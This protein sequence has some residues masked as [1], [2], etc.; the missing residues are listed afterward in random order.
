MYLFNLKRE[1][2]T[3]KMLFNSIQFLIFFI[4][5]TAVYFLIHHKYKWALLLAASIFFYM[6][7]FPIYILI[8]A[9]LILLT[10]FSAKLIE[11][12]S[13][14]KKRNYFIL[15]LIFTCAALFVFKYFN[16]FNANISELA[17]FLHWNYSMKTLS[18]I[19]PIGLSF[20]TF[21]SLSYIIEVYRGR[22]KAEKHLG[23]YSLYILFYPQLVAGPIERPYNLIHQ[24]YEEHKFE[25]QRVV[26][27]LQL[28]LWGFFLKVVIADRAAM[29]VNPIYDNIRAYSGVSLIIAT[30]LFAFQIFCDFA[31][32]SII[33]I[34][35]AKIMGFELMTN[36]KRPYFSKS[37]AEFWRRWH[38]SLS[39]WFKDYVYFPL[40]GS[41]VRKRRIIFN[42][43]VVFLISGLWHG[44]AWTFLIWGGLHGMYM[45]IS[46]LTRH[47]REKIN[48]NINIKINPKISTAIQVF[49]TFNLVCLGWIF[50]RAN[51]VSDAWYIITHLFS[52]SSL[53]FLTFNVAGMGNLIITVFFIFVLETVHYIQEKRGISN[54]FSKMPGYI[55]RLCYVILL[56][57]ILLFGVFNKTPFIYFQF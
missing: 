40:G 7:M 38:I 25:V 56:L 3:N 1:N 8:P 21:Q 13:G 17:K 55:R 34:G 36:F 29:I 27:G 43:L 57:I 50:F 33:A 31:G 18:L 53:S 41:R 4:I 20:Y 24:F 14:K 16:F 54:T 35:C 42:W 32:Y 22:Q 51:S 39:T 28:M 30:Y 44:A 45:V 2:S 12:S 19:L 6:A 10:F 23:I 15:C 26:K 9:S 5:I 11:T 47:Y 49:I 46:L 48:K 37:I 52:N